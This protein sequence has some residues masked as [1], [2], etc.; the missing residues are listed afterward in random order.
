MAFQRRAHSRR[1]DGCRSQVVALLLLL[2]VLYCVTA[3]LGQGRDD[4]EQASS[5]NSWSDSGAIRSMRKK[6][7]Q[8]ETSYSDASEYNNGGVLRYSEVSN[9]GKAYT[10]KVDGRF[11]RLGGRRTLILAAGM[12]SYLFYSEGSDWPRFFK[13]AR[14]AGCNAVHSNVIWGAHEQTPDVYDFIRP[15]A[16]LIKFAQMAAAHDLFLILTVL[17][18]PNAAWTNHGLPVWLDYDLGSHLAGGASRRREWHLRKWFR[19]LRR[20]LRP[21]SAAVGGPLILLHVDGTNQ[22]SL[23]RSFFFAKPLSGRRARSSKQKLSLPVERTGKHSFDKNGISSPLQR[24]ERLDAVNLSPRVSARDAGLDPVGGREEEEDRSKE[25][26]D[27]W[28]DEQD[29]FEEEDCLR[30]H[31]CWGKHPRTCDP[32]VAWIADKNDGGAVPILEGNYQ[33]DATTFESGAPSSP[34]GT[35]ISAPGRSAKRNFIGAMTGPAGGSHDSLAGVSTA[36]GDIRATTSSQEAGN[37][38]PHVEQGPGFE[39]LGQKH[40]PRCSGATVLST[41]LEL[42]APGCLLSHEEGSVELPLEEKDSTVAAVGPGVGSEHEAG[43]RRGTA[44]A[45]CIPSGSVSELSQREK[46]PIVTGD[47]SWSRSLQALCGEERANKSGERSRSP[48]RM[49][50]PPGSPGDALS[51]SEEVGQLR[52]QEGGETHEHGT[53]DLA[54][55]GHKN[56]RV[57]GGQAGPDS[58][59]DERCRHGRRSRAFGGGVARSRG[60][61][62]SLQTAVR[63]DG[64]DGLLPPRACSHLGKGELREAGESK[65]STAFDLE[66]SEEA[67]RSQD[68]NDGQ[69]RSDQTEG[70]CVHQIPR[71]RRH[72]P[73]SR[74]IWEELEHTLQLPLVYSAEQVKSD[75]YEG[76]P[77]EFTDPLAAELFGPR[78]T[79]DTRVPG[80]V[81]MGCTGGTCMPPAGGIRGLPGSRFRSK[82]FAWAERRERGAHNRAA[83]VF[84]LRSQNADGDVLWRHCILRGVPCIWMGAPTIDSFFASFLKSRSSWRA[85]FGLT[86]PVPDD[87]LSVLQQSPADLL[88]EEREGSS[89]WDRLVH[90]LQGRTVEYDS[91]DWGS[92][93]SRFFQ[94]LAGLFFYSVLGGRQPVFPYPARAPPFSSSPLSDL[95]ENTKPAS[96]LPSFSS[97]SGSIWTADWAAA[98]KS[99]TLT[100]IPVDLLQDALRF[101]AFGGTIIV[102]SPFIE[103]NPALSLRAQSADSMSYVQGKKRETK[104]IRDKDLEVALVPPGETVLDAPLSL[105]EDP[106]HFNSALHIDDCS[107]DR[108]PLDTWAL[109]RWPVLEL[110][111]YLHRFV[112]YYSSQLLARG[113]YVTPV[114]KRAHVEV[115]AFRSLDIVCNTHVKRH[116]Q[117]TVSSKKRSSRVLSLSPR[118]CL[119]YAKG[120]D[121][122]AAERQ[123]ALVYSTAVYRRQSRRSVQVLQAFSLKGIYGRNAGYPVRPP[124]GESDHRNWGH[125]NG[126]DSSP[127]G[128]TPGAFREESAQSAKAEDSHD[129]LAQGARKQRSKDGCA[130]GCGED[131]TVYGTTSEKRS[132]TGPDTAARVVQESGDADGGG[133]FWEAKHWSQGLIA[134]A[135][136]PRRVTPQIWS[137]TVRRLRPGRTSSVSALNLGPAFCLRQGAPLNAVLRTLPVLSVPQWFTQGWTDFVW[138]ELD[139]LPTGLQNGADS[140]PSVFGPTLSA[141]PDSGRSELPPSV[142]EIRTTGNSRIHVFSKG[143]LLGQ[144][145]ALEG[146]TERRLLSERGQMPADPTSPLKILVPARSRRIVILSSAGPV[147]RGTADLA[148]GSTAFS[149]RRL[150]SCLAHCITWRLRSLGLW[151]RWCISPRSGSAPHQQRKRLF[152]RGCAGIPRPSGVHEILWEGKPVEPSK[153]CIG[154]TS[155]PQLQHGIALQ[156]FLE[157]WG[158]VTPSHLAGW[159]GEQFEKQQTVSERA[160]PSES[161]RKSSV[162]SFMPL[163]DEVKDAASGNNGVQGDAAVSRY[164]HWTSRSFRALDGQS[165]PSRY[166]LVVWTVTRD[167]EKK[168]KRQQLPR[169]TRGRYRGR[170]LC[171]DARRGRAYVNSRFAGFYWIP[172]VR[173][174]RAEFARRRPGRLSVLLKIPSDWILPGSNNLLL[175]DEVGG[176]GAGAEI[177]QEFLDGPAVAFSWLEYAFGGLVLVLLGL[178]GMILLTVVV[179]MCNERHRDRQ[180]G[181][182]ETVFK[183]IVQSFNAAEL[184]SPPPSRTSSPSCRPCSSGSPEGSPPLRT[185]SS[186]RC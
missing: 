99:D 164:F 125:S 173:T 186:Y 9:Y 21:L 126:R 180:V 15:S 66:Q 65:C 144:S 84:S 115:F 94:Q 149:W 154:L 161:D 113:R 4:G 143:K 5:Y 182:Q 71:R 30:D 3:S 152:P 73:P 166:N 142:L 185:P 150:F 16:N 63:H 172:P 18:A 183:Q 163:G 141:T 157:S 121:P 118:S 89:L 79:R 148:V 120:H 70:S 109:P 74:T 48:T 72:L 158:F 45:S 160:A 103:E 140:P 131:S 82:A 43:G 130:A 33:K 12:S 177:I 93:V 22:E 129:L 106:C 26:R 17:P 6:G 102:Y 25:D 67:E 77:V 98:H 52:S 110:V 40:K 132:G 24:E 169:L 56:L 29:H 11:L 137:Q 31:G 170:E 146:K 55:T 49:A 81:L 58:P 167:C 133:P 119:G 184:D 104:A 42:R 145:S 87:V 23:V 36:A 128:G 97:H 39:T 44:S 7:E 14:D 51:A 19:V 112:G 78:S 105:S 8:R 136:G 174:K 62:S 86:S 168:K 100:A 38:Y 20:I 181:L 2:S 124:T 75:T 179:L 111:S 171:A 116:M 107:P 85:F 47:V 162:G 54:Q 32:S 91:P 59:H 64:I 165:S 147:R 176:H 61:S 50:Q 108:P 96:L 95:A 139:F 88:G 10:V 156:T 153:R 69:R 151:L 117:F 46:D 155:E 101:L 1:L 37:N 135:D 114:F 41:L 175:L 159:R 122:R 57:V 92:R 123:L 35:V 134:L 60:W 127:A 53:H 13:R 138:Y 76:K 34:Q 178:M 90:F 80:T 28:C 27:E 68:N 83:G